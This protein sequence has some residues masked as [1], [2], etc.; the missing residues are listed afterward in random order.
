MATQTISD[1]SVDEFKLLIKETVAETLAEMLADPDSGYV[2]QPSI[3][4]RLKE[5][6]A[7]LQ[8]GIK[9]IPA[10]DLATELGLEW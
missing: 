1:L 10:D 4:E 8:K 2:L 5:S 6:A 9:T 7:A 3:E